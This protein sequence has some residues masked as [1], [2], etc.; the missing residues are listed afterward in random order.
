MSGAAAPMEWPLS[1]WLTSWLR[2][3]GRQTWE[4]VISGLLPNLGVLDQERFLPAGMGMGL[5]GILDS[6][7]LM[8]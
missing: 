5:G 4:G 8:L 3:V 7:G 1:L 2:G 6:Y